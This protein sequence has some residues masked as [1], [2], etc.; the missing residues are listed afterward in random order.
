MFQNS[1]L[2]WF[3]HEW[4]PGLDNAESLKLV[5]LA[6]EQPRNTLSEVTRRDLKIWKVS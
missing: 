3:G 1:S 6:G 5:Y 4:V 2:P